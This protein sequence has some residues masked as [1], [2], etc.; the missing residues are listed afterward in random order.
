[1]CVIGCDSNSDVSCNVRPGR[2]GVADGKIE[3]VGCWCEAVCEAAMGDE[4]EAA[5]AI[6]PALARRSF[7]IEASTFTILNDHKLT[8]RNIWKKNGD[9]KFPRCL[10]PYYGGQ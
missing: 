2:V 7:P 8:V 1:M 10:L 3:W 4:R 9:F 6:T 5:P